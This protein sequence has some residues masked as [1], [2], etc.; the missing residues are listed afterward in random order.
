MDRGD[1]PSLPWEDCKQCGGIGERVTPRRGKTVLCHCVFRRALLDALGR[2]HAAEHKMSLRNRLFRCD[3]DIA[4]RVL[5]PHEQAVWEYFL[6]CGIDWD[7][8]LRLGDRRLVG[9]T[10]GNFFHT[11]YATEQR[12]GRELIARGIA[13]SAKYF[14]FGRSETKPNGIVTYGGYIDTHRPYVNANSGGSRPGM[15]K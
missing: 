14:S 4:A 12:M 7:V 8:C 2:Y 13:P 1:I 5:A 9:M 3:V 11:V 15:W 10:R 6:K